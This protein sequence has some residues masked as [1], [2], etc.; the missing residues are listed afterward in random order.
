MHSDSIKAFTGMK[1]VS[2]LAVFYTSVGPALGLQAISE[3]FLTESDGGA[4]K[5]GLSKCFNSE[6]RNMDNLRKT[7]ARLEKQMHDFCE[8]AFAASGSTI[9]CGLRSWLFDLL[10]CCMG[11]V[12][13]GEKGPFGDAVFRHNLRLVVQ[14]LPLLGRPIALLVPSKLRSARAYVRHCIGKSIARGA[15]A[16]GDGKHEEK[17]LFAQ[18]AR[19]YTSLEMPRDCYSDCHLAVIVGLISNVINLISWGVCH[20]V[21]DPELQVLLTTELKG[22]GLDFG[23]VDE[24]SDPATAMVD[25]DHIRNACPLLMATWY[26]LLRVYADAPVVRR[27]NKD[28]L[29]GKDIQLENG[30]VIVTPIHLRNFDEAIWGADRHVFRP[31]RFL[32]S[33]ERRKIDKALVK[34]LVVFGLPGMHQCPGRYLG[35]TMALTVLAKIM[36]NLEIRPKPGDSL[37]RGLV[38]NRNETM[39][40]LPALGRDPQ[41][42][43]RRCAESR[44]VRVGYDNLK[45]GW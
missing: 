5:M 34:H 41:V 13:W 27:L 45:P 32:Q 6:L 14:N 8:D 43:M 24:P 9:D 37:E 38:P 39:L 16:E 36:V 25:I 4:F 21:A 1:H 28:S 23:T 35:L 18:L 33:Q 2:L 17:T 22:A 12:F 26:E 40:G 7:A 42:T 11:A 30:S 10:S 15:Y 19:L 29:F 44:T 20:I 31:S 3:R